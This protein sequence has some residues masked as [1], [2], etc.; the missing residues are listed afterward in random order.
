MQFAIGA[1]HLFRGLAD[2][3]ALPAVPKDTALY[4]VFERGAV[5]EAEHSFYET[6]HELASAFDHRNGTTDFMTMLQFTH[7]STEETEE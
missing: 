6:A 5:R 1:Y 3:A 7:P 4:P 2:D